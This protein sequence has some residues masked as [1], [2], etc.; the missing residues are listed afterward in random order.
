[1]RKG[2][3]AAGHRLTARAAAEI[4]EAGG[5]AFDAVLAAHL[6]A[7]VAEPVLA[8]L[9]GGGFLLAAP[10]DGPP[11]L[12][13]FFAQTPRR[14]RPAAEID[15][16][17]ILADFGTATQEFHIGYGTI[18]TPGA[19]RGWFDVHRDLGRL[20]MREIAEPAVRLAREGVV[21][22]EL[23]AY[24]FSVVAPIYLASAPVRAVFG[25]EADPRR[26][27]GEGERVRNPQLADAIETLAIEGADLF[28]RGE[29][30]R[31]LV[32]ACHERGG[33]LQRDDLERYAV[34]LRR[35]LTLDYRD[36]RIHTN[37]PPASGG[38]LIG[39][40]LSLLD[41][42]PPGGNGFGSYPHLRLLAEAMRQANAARRQAQSGPEGTLD[43]ARLLDA[44]TL[45]RY[46]AALRNR[47]QALRGTTHISVMDARGNRASMTVSNGEGCGCFIEGTGIMPNNML[48][49]DDLN[50]G[51]FHRWRQDVRLTSMMSPSVASSRHGDVIVT[52]SGGSNRIRSAL[53]QVFVNL[54]DFQ[55]DVERAVAAPRIHLEGGRLS[56]EAG[57]DPA[58]VERLVADFPEHEIWETTNLFFG[59]AHTLLQRGGRL[60]GAG[61]PRRDGVC[62][63]V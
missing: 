52:G 53:L 41:P 12:Y 45:S 50:P 13:D 44:E 19:V 15:F 20:P 6:T 10:A 2:I 38:V 54:I 42:F 28:Y 18:A 35:P 14:K 23:Q 16:R 5:S 26:L 22:D 11:R 17:P 51:G 48:G 7:C 29:M 36:W 46:R 27:K 37:P 40:A 1:M 4:L 3:V 25:S 62:M 47:A 8:S 43:T 9:G 21:L 60:T 49:E 61:D 56:I 57:F 58:V 63:V 24:I 32:A 59:G 39:F 34:E 30:G 33:H 55:M 31:A